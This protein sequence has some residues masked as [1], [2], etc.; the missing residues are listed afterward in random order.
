MGDKAIG[1]I[2]FQLCWKGLMAAA[3]LFLPISGQ[4]GSLQGVGGRLVIDK[5]LLEKIV[6]PLLSSFNARQILG[7]KR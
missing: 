2:L 5:N 3:M 7:Q 1:S 4:A 6:P